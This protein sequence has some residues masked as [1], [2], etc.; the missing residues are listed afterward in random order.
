MSILKT[1]TTKFQNGNPTASIVVMLFGTC[2]NDCLFC[3]QKPFRH[4]MSTFDTLTADIQVYVKLLNQQLS[5]FANL[6]SVS[7]SLMG[8]ELFCYNTTQH[9]KALIDVVSKYSNAKLRL[10][11]N[12]MFKKLDNLFEIID[13]CDTKQLNYQLYTSFDFG[14]LRYQNQKVL[15]LFKHNVDIVTNKLKQ[16]GRLLNVEVI[17]TK[18]MLDA[19]NIDDQYAQYF[20]HLIDCSNISLSE[21]S[22]SFPF[23]LAYDQSIELWRVLIDRFYKYDC[24]RNRFTESGRNCINTQRVVITGN[25]VYEGCSALALSTLVN[26]DSKTKCT[27]MIKFVQHYG[28]MNCR[29]FNRCS[30]GCLTESLYPQCDIKIARAYYEKIAK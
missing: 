3:F 26:D 8:G 15:D 9:L 21:L 10:A 5:R 17:R 18:S 1:V 7:V 11:S 20:N 30:F 12:L 19:F 24:V 25:A 13:Y 2:N 23:S 29:Y 6:P 22:G 14:S 16:S 27:R 28:C 4:Q